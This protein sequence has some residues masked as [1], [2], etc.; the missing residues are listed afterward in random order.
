[1]IAKLPLIVALCSV[2]LIMLIILPQNNVDC[3]GE[4]SCLKG[5]IKDIV[6]GNTVETEDSVV[7]LSLIA[8]NELDSTNVGDAKKFVESICPV[9]S[10][11]LVDED[12]G[13]IG[14]GYGMIVG[15]VFCQGIILNEKILENQPHLLDSV[16]CFSSEFANEEWAK[17]YGC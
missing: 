8:L 16:Q 14:S 9:G 3:S 2:P 15:K 11:V 7:A 1:M 10:D 17:K 6:N 5:K 13:Q 12:D 4:A